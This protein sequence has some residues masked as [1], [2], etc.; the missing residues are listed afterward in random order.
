MQIG[1]NR[2]KRI[3]LLSYSEIKALATGNLLII[4]KYNLDNATWIWRWES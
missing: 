4:G 2:S 1:R 3:T